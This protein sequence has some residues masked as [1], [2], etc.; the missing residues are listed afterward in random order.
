MK[1]RTENCLLLIDCQKDFCSP[2]GSLY[3]QGAEKD[4]ERIASFIKN[5]A[6]ELDKIV[7]SLDSHHYLHISHPSMWMDKNGNNPPPHTP[8]SYQDIMDGK[9]SPRPEFDRKTMINYVKQLEEQG[10]LSHYIWPYHCII[11]STMASLDD[12]VLDAINF[13]EKETGRL[14]VPYTKGGFLYSESFG[15]FRCNVIYPNIPETQLNLEIITM[16]ETYN[17]VFFGGQARTHC[18]SQS[19][20]QVMNEAPG[21]AKKFVI[22]EDFMSD[23]VVPGGPDFHAM[24]QPIYDQAKQMGIR[25]EKSTNINLTPAHAL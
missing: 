12:S 4:C 9:W 14:S 3:V 2:K 6:H 11:G 16:M 18:V 1:N 20:R 10:E 21:L 5:N 23:V 22:V 25:F 24:C 17:F 7:F 15:I 13:W 19:L 8:M